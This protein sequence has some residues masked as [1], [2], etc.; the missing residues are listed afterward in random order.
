MTF[1]EYLR[2]KHKKSYYPDIDFKIWCAS[3]SSFYWVGYAEQWHREALD[4]MVKDKV[5]EIKEAL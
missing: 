2:D 5:K 3:L 4:E 1:E